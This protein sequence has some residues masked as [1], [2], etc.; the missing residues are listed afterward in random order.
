MGQHTWFLK[1]K[2]LYE[3]QNRLYEKLDKHEEGEIYLDDM[4]LHQLNHEIDTIDNQNQTEYHDVFRTNKRN[5]NNTY[6]NDVLFSKDECFK[7]INN[8]DNYVS[9][10]HTI[11]DTDEQEK[12]NKKIAIQKLNEFWDKYP[13][14]VIYFG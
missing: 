14:G 8:P 12:L 4:E 6:T 13:D 7:W 3:K 1:N 5:T 11:F 9:F 10:K 2:E